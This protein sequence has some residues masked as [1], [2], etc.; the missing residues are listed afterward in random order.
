MIFKKKCY[1][2]KADEPAVKRGRGRP[3]KKVV[4]KS[5]VKKVQ[6]VVTISEESAGEDLPSQ[7]K[8]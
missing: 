8:F 6:K 2:K 3:P 1:V 4:A 5:P 7:V